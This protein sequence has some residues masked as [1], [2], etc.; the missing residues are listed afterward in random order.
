MLSQPTLPLTPGAN[1]YPWRHL[2]LIAPEVNPIHSMI[3]A[4]EALYLHWLARDYYQG[5]GEIVDG[6]PLLGGSTYA[7]ASGLSANMYVSQKYKRIHSYDLFQYF[8]DFGRL[9][10]GT[11]L[12]LG[13]DLLPFFLENTRPYQDSIEAHPG[14]IL[15]WHWTGQPIEILFIDLAKS[16]QINNHVI[17]EFFGCLLPGRSIV[18]QQDYFHYYCYWLHLVME[19]FQPYFQI[20]HDPDGATLSFLLVKEIPKGLLT[21]DYEKYFTKQLAVQ[22]MDQAVARF[23]GAKR[24]MLLAAKARMLCDYQDYEWALAVTSEIRQSPD[25]H[26]SVLYDLVHAEA[27]IPSEVLLRGTRGKANLVAF[28]RNY[29]IFGRDDRLYAVPHS[30]IEFDIDN[31]QESNAPAVLTAKT[32]EEMATLIGEAIQPKPDPASKLVGHYKNH[33][34]VEYDYQVYALP[35]SLGPVDLSDEL[36]RKYSGFLAAETTEDVRQLING[37]EVVSLPINKRL[38]P[39]TSQPPTAYSFLLPTRNNPGGLRRFFES[40]L[41]TTARPEE[42]EIILAID[43]DDLVSQAVDHSGLNIKKIV[44]PHGSPM[45][46]LNRACFNLASGKFIMLVNDDIVLRTSGWDDRIRSVIAEYPDE[47]VLIH[48]NDLLFREKLCTF[49]MLSRKAC[50]YIGVCPQEYK[51][52]RIDDHIYDTYS[53]LAYLGHPRII[54]LPDVIFEHENHTGQAEPDAAHTF[55][56]SD[57]KT[58]L[59]NQEIILEDAAYFELTFERRK[60]DAARLAQ[61]IGIFR[62]NTWQERATQFVI[63]GQTFASEELFLNRLAPLR[64]SLSYRRPDFIRVQSQSDH[65]RVTI[66]IVT[67]DVR[68][69]HA[70]ECI[71]RVKDY[72]A[73]Y[74]LL[75]LDN[76]RRPNFNHPREMNKILRTAETNFVVLMD[77]DVYVEAGWLEGLFNCMDDQTG[78]VAPLHRNRV[79]DLSFAG[80]YFSGDQQGSHDHLIDHPARPRAA[81]TVCSAIILIDLHKCSGIWMDESYAKYFL[82]LDYSLQVWEA[83]HKVV[84]TPDVIVTHLGGATLTHGSIQAN[85]V[86]DRDRQYF[87]NRWIQSE[88]LAEIENTTWQQYS[89]LQPLTEIPRQII[90]FFTSPPR[91][92]FARK[93]TSLVEASRSYSQF[94]KLLEAN[95][96]NYLSDSEMAADS[97]QIIACKNGLKVVQTRLYGPS[98][99]VAKLRQLQ[100]YIATIWHLLWTDP[101][102]LTEKGK[103]WLKR[104]RYAERP[105]LVQGTYYDFNI[106]RFQ[107]RYY[108]LALALGTFRLEDMT[109]NDIARYQRE[110]LIVTS[111]TVALVK[112][113]IWLLAQQIKLLNTSLNHHPYSKP[114]LIQSG[115]RGYNLVSYQGRVY[116]L[117]MSLGS[118]ALEQLATAEL[119]VHQ[120]SG[121]IMV[122]YSPLTLKARIIALRLWQGWQ[123]SRNVVGGP[124]LIQNHFHGYNLVHYGNWFYGL[125]LALGPLDLASLDENEFQRYAPQ[126]LVRGSNL[127]FVKA[128][129]LWYRLL[130]KLA[131]R[132]L[133]SR[134]SDRNK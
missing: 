49:P 48:V 17:R 65:P 56:S 124:I 113:Q 35:H 85:D 53:M 41:S 22:L 120:Q 44:V 21:V 92:G 77:D 132:G 19:Y 121:A 125:S 84:V 66:A 28:S 57:N 89:E 68:N 3:G 58:Y 88:R 23:T 108:G 87:I 43:D 51:R 69:A 72:T 86:Q 50:D 5:L 76:S 129:I 105:Q 96:E 97:A 55:K 128:R 37:K 7:M 14:D 103:R 20:V 4:D 79:G 95:L 59:P 13:D 34:L 93:L 123:L 101:T 47:I 62:R 109:R 60:Q 82:D 24:L 27:L 2:G 11:A 64:D 80:V 18:V 45:G 32:L 46:G 74:D 122:G 6:G 38:A 36:I 94:E 106:V 112:W 16:W 133:S 67:A 117:A 42:L 29:D 26:D 98:T 71:R 102:Q 83:G 54:Y 131:E 116:G 15:N 100:D 61:L 126:Q 107:W 78:L 12:K 1:P 130:A 90:E 118:L 114:H 119:N 127:Q 25:W 111:Y 70:A 31:V 40:I 104:R 52:Y 30:W 110:G 91:E 99:Q 33:S 63:A 9:L 8:P 39:K 115:Y 75:I 134:P 73:N 10:P 81:Q